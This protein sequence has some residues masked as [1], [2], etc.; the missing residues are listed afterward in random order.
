MDLKLDIGAGRHTLPGFVAIDR[1]YGYEAYPL[2]DTVRRWYDSGN[3][4]EDVELSDGSVSE[5]RASHVLEHFGWA[6]V[7]SVLSEWAR[8]LK[9][10]GRIRVAVPDFDKI[11][12][13]LRD[14][15][16]NFLYLMGGQTDENDFH[17]SAFTEETLC[18]ALRAAGLQVTGRWESDQP[19][20]ARLPVSLNIEAV[21]PG[22]M[23]LNNVRQ[24]TATPKEIEP[25]PPQLEP[26]FHAGNI[27][28]GSGYPERS[29]VAMASIPRLGWQDH[30]GQ[31]ADVLLPMG[32]PVWRL[33]G[34][35]WGQMLQTGMEKAVAAGI[36]WILVLDY[37]TMFTESHLRALFRDFAA[38]DDI[39]ALTGMQPRR[40]T[41][42]PLMTVKDAD[43]KNVSGNIE[44]NGSPLRVGTMHF[45]CTLIKVGALRKMPK[46][47]FVGVP[48]STGSWTDDDRWDPDIHFW[49]R[50][51][52]CGNTAYVSPEVF[53][54]HLELYVSEFT[55]VS[56]NNRNEKLLTEPRNVPVSDWIKR[57]RAQTACESN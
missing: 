44:L 16:K 34:A 13:E 11:A 39:D 56:V 9:P 28:F 40:N 23:D 29:I 46:P 1:K 18:A 45:G 33:S 10:G 8:V 15:P 5:I 41:C 38:R 48:G 42:E 14:D 20:C 32:I 50:W 35:F 49:K 55:Q 3:E 47:W 21:K 37:D 53:L 27:N 4:C 25:T 22:E 6:E 51:E 2:P 19:D 7:P 36:D 26:G 54:G 31:I 57:E 43:G 52:E 24:E 12:D 30:W 17:K